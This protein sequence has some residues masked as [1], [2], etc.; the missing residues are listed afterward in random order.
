[1]KR[2]GRSFYFNKYGN[3]VYTSKKR[4]C[5]VHTGKRGGKFIMKRKRGGG[6]RKVYK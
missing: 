2:K 4:T 3:K 1:M 6:A 5:K